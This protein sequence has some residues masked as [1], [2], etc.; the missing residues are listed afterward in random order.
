MKILKIS[1]VR[2]KEWPICVSATRISD[3]MYYLFGYVKTV[4]SIYKH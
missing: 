1:I 4:T 3:F 2:D